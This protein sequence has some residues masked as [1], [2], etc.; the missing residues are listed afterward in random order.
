[1]GFAVNFLQEFTA[2]KPVR[3]TILLISRLVE[4]EKSVPRGGQP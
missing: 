3:D 2:K 1:M 4:A